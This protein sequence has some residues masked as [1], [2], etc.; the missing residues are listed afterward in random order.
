MNRV[1]LIEDH[2]HLAK[3]LCKGLAASGIAADV[4]DRGEAAWSAVRQL[5]YQ[6]MV[7]DRGLPDGDGLVL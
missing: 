1:L 7:L 3:L 6:A 2:E 5:P 4:V